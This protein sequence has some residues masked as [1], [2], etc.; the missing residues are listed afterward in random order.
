MI[1]ILRVS[2]TPIFH[3]NSFRET[4][5]IKILGNEGDTQHSPGLFD[6]NKVKEKDE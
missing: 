1:D 3:E 6:E 2:L 4:L 5:I